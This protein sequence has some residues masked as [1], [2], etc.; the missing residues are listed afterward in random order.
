M[1]DLP[2][3]A[4]EVKYVA[5]ADF[6]E[7]TAAAADAQAKL[8]AL[9][10]SADE[11][12]KSQTASNDAVV[13]SEKEKQ[14]A[15]RDSALAAAQLTQQQNLLN[16]AENHGFSSPQEAKAF[17]DQQTQSQVN[18]N[19]ALNNGRTTPDQVLA[20]KRN[21]TQ[22]QNDANASL[23]DFNAEL[24]DLTKGTSDANKS[25]ADLD[26]TVVR[27]GDDS[28]D[29]GTKLHSLAD[30]V[31]T[32]SRSAQDAERG[33]TVI[34]TA[35]GDV[36][37][38]TERLDSSLEKTSS[39]LS[40][41][42]SVT[43]TGADSTTSL[44]DT[45]GAAQSELDG[46]SASFLEYQAAVKQ[47]SQTSGTVRPESLT[48]VASSSAVENRLRAQA[49]ANAAKLTEGSGLLSETSLAERDRRARA[50]QSLY[51][52][53]ESLASPGQSSIGSAATA[54]ASS[55]TSKVTP[56]SKEAEK[57]L[58][59]L[60]EAVAEVST[61]FQGSSAYGVAL[62]ARMD[63][64]D[65]K[66]DS[67]RKTAS[68]T[69]YSTD[70]FG[71]LDKLVKQYD[72]VYKASQKLDDPSATRWLTDTRSEMD[73]FAV[74]L[75]SIVKDVD[76]AGIHTGDLA[77]EFESLSERSGSVNSTMGVLFAASLT[78]ADDKIQKLSV[79]LHNGEGTFDSFTASIK[80]SNT[81]L[82]SLSKQAALLDDPAAV[83]SV[84]DLRTNLDT[85]TLTVLHSRDSLE[86][87]RAAEEDEAIVS[88]LS[89][90][91]LADFIK[92]SESSK[93][94]TDDAATGIKDL[95]GYTGL[96]S[97][98][99][100]ELAHKVDTFSAAV[101]RAGSSKFVSTIFGD[102]TPE[103]GALSSAVGGVANLV[104]MLGTVSSAAAP[105]LALGIALPTVVS[106]MAALGGAAVGV[107]GAM[108]PL[109]GIV[110]TFLPI[111][112]GMGVA[113][114][115]VMVAIKPFETAFTDLN[116]KTAAAKK[117]FDSFSKPIQQVVEDVN[118]LGKAFGG[119]SKFASQL[120]TD[121]ATPLTGALSG[122]STIVKPL[123]GAMTTM[124]S[125]I[126][127]AAAPV[128]KNVLSFIDSAG[129]KTIVSGASVG[130]VA[131]GGTLSNILSIIETI[132]VDATPYM[133]TIA[134]GF[135]TL[136]S[137]I[138]KAVTAGS[139]DG[140]IND[141]FNQMIVALKI[142]EG[143][144]SGVIG[145]VSQWGEALAPLG[146][147]IGV[148][149][150]KGLNDVAAASNNID[151]FKWITAIEQF[152]SGLKTAVSGIASIIK[153]LI[154]PEFVT[155][156]GDVLD[157]VGKI[158]KSFSPIVDFV[159]KLVATALPALR[160][161]FDG[162]AKVVET[163]F[164]WVDKFLGALEQHK[165][166]MMV[167]KDL[168][169]GLGS[170]V[171]AGGVLSFLSM[172]GGLASKGVSGIISLVKSLA[173]LIPGVNLGG[174]SDGEATEADML[175]TAAEELSTAAEK[176]TEAAEKLSTAA[177]EEETAATEEETAAGE[178]ATASTDEEL[179]ATE[180]EAASADSEVAST[181]DEL[182]DTDSE[183]A[184]TAT[185]A[186]DVDTGVADTATE[187]ADVDTV[188]ADTDSELASTDSE[189]AS[190]DSEIASTAMEALAAGKGL[191]GIFGG[192]T[193]I[194]SK[195]FGGSGGSGDSGSPKTP[196]PTTIDFNKW[197]AGFNAAWMKDV[198]QP[199][200]KFVQLTIPGLFDSSEKTW[201]TSFS[202]VLDKSVEVPIQTFVNKTVPGYWA[203]SIPTWFTS[204]QA[205]LTKG[206]GTPFQ[207]L[208]SKTVPGYWNSSIP[209]WFSTVPVTLDKYVS[210]PMDTVIKSEIPGFWQESIVM[211][212][213]TADTYMTEDI[214]DPMDDIIADVALR[215]Q[216]SM[217]TWFNG[218]GG[219][220][221][222]LV[223]NPAVAAITGIAEAS[224][225]AFAAAINGVT[226]LINNV[227]ITPVDEVLTFGS[228]NSSPIPRIP[229]IKY[230]GG[231]HVA[232]N[233]GENDTSDSTVAALTPGEYVLRKRAAAK[234]GP[235]ALDWLN[236]ADTN[237]ASVL[238]YTQENAKSYG[239]MSRFAGGGFVGSL[240]EDGIS[241]VQ[242]S[243]RSAFDD[244]YNATAA[245]L[246]K[247]IGDT[248]LPGAIGTMIGQGIKKYGD[249][250]L[251]ADDMKELSELGTI[252]TGARLTVLEGALSAAGVA[253]SQWPTWEA[254]L[255]T[256]ITR[257]SDWN[258]KAVNRTDANAKAGHPS[259]GLAQ[260]IPST[261]AAYHVNGTSSDIFDPVANVAAAIK[262]IEANYGS[263]TKVQQ[264]NA[265]EPPKGYAA[266][267]F[268][269]NLTGGMGFATPSM[270]AMASA[271]YPELSSTLSPGARSANGMSSGSG[272]H[273]DNFNVSN[274][275]PEQSSDSL[276]RSM[277]K[278]RVYG[279]RG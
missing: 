194:L 150:V 39:N 130:L 219:V 72:S 247:N 253:K 277:T 10:A 57:S 53:G 145:I 26:S 200:D 223:S 229:Y 222:S 67:L 191:T 23:S 102:L 197:L 7:L 110:A 207:T 63:D 159:A 34:E 181:A 112:V 143:V 176:L 175:K 165:D 59:D 12:N 244:L 141:F 135:D 33:L 249:S 152:L 215:W 56:A 204:F 41:Y 214:L 259:E 29:S 174:G 71:A 242:G 158:A 147:F 217:P 132:A 243:L 69:G 14:A 99:F 107:V 126:G 144:L 30:A 205:G 62:A 183:A 270:N 32:V 70:L 262:Y 47:A 124:A 20:D 206:V 123:Q 279:G 266:G 198:V 120:A 256:L 234:L 154:K 36:R 91:N 28:E 228:N 111:V 60:S 25:T 11:L 48:P 235:H 51:E 210:S 251:G 134:K 161:E 129:F 49:A 127:Q 258:P 267:G 90:Q 248:S 273:I 272:V 276:A 86:A 254:G 237:G 255:N 162:I 55:L 233:L 216:K 227:I 252:P 138:S 6:E 103:S 96:L 113:F 166:V 225:K 201:F 231:G 5:R 180:S 98:T 202:S 241:F 263:I 184:S 82:L 31:N 64:L 43:K 269:G 190:T 106:G 148:G 81:E 170:L 95:W 246:L 66:L 85:L 65:K 68:T 226:G 24:K 240:I 13:R 264:A 77:G 121:I 109:V 92:A 209:Q 192:I 52:E 128:I 74:T 156:L 160:T 79:D 220:I 224:A 78:A 195:L 58:S 275:L 142:L 117:S 50:G 193:G 105:L 46:L 250:L 151:F 187:A 239:K 119:T 83:R 278:L 155:F 139:K 188:A 35:L 115:T 3:D 260:T 4:Y 19:K 213:K 257:E 211:W 137:S 94:S 40:D 114:G 22:A 17:Q 27:L 218:L 265:S 178:S 80:K 1:S 236:H 136:T 196:N 153:A 61:G 9:K 186:A 185:E 73:E 177:G 245:P 84:D 171:I 232:G 271:A 149:L 37:A 104:D 108:A 125:A 179:A 212:F 238:P 182:A 15:M 157:Q 146:N 16:R 54:L 44:A 45:F 100:G 189:I 8:A 88:A 163:V 76:S 42:S 38:E 89:K 261:F 21:A 274:P 97:D 18:Y 122:L 167:L 172:L 140:S 116:T 173:N 199:V 208:V 87:L 75:Q 203:T 268:A 164:N 93:K 169:V 101:S 133:V 230:A 2:G 221:Q 131:F 168:V 118:N